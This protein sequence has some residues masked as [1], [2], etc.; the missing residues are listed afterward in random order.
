MAYKVINEKLGIKSCS[1][2]DLTAKQVNNFLSQWEDGA[3]IGSLT[4]FYEKD[5]G[6]VVLN[7]DHAN[8]EKSLL[9]TETYLSATTEVREKML[10]DSVL[11]GLK[12]SIQV[13]QNAVDQRKVKVWLKRIGYLVPEF[14]DPVLRAIYKEDDGMFRIWK[15]YQYGVMQG[16]R[17]ERTRKKQKK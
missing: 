1:V 7:Q 16:K 3:K 6:Y 17:Q 12:E 11:A 8:Y 4:L 13:L 9:L 5:T 14:S 15:A 10:N 2:S